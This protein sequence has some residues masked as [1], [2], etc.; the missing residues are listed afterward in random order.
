MSSKT[1]IIYNR[2]E[3]VLIVSCCPATKK[4]FIVPRIHWHRIISSK[5]FNNQDLAYTGVQHYFNVIKLR[6]TD[7]S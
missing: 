2:I 4:Y 3:L 7:D 6:M 1:E 5:L